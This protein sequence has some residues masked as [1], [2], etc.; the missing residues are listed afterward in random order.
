MQLNYGK[1]PCGGTYES[2]TI[3]VPMTIEGESVVLTDV[4]QGA[5]PMCRSWVYKVDVLEGLEG[6]MKRSLIRDS[7][8]AIGLKPSE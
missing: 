4:P 6:L 7:L 3:K 1:C 2:R 8:A 5:C